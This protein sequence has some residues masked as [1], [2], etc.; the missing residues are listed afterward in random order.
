MRKWRFQAVFAFLFLPNPP[1]TTLFYPHVETFWRPFYFPH[2]KSHR[3][4]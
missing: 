3:S 2:K 1:K 4:G